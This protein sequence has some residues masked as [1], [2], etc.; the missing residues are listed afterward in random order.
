MVEHR[1]S[2][3]P[4][5]SW[6]VGGPADRLCLA[7]TIEQLSTFLAELA[8]QEPLFWM[9]RGSNLLIRDGG[10]RGTVVM[11]NQ[12]GEGLSQPDEGMIRAEAGVSLSR[13]SRFA[14]S[15]G[16]QALDFVAGIPGSVGGALAM[17]AG[18]FG[19]EIWELVESVEVINRQGKCCVRTPEEYRIDYRNVEL[20]EPHEEWFVAATFSQ[21]CYH[22]QQGCLNVQQQ[23]RQRNQSQPMAEYS[24]GS[25]FRNPPGDHA[26]RLIE[27]AGLK[28]CCI[29]GAC[30]STHH[31]NFIVHRG[32]A[33]AAEIEALMN[34]VQQTVEQQSGVR[35]EP[36]VK[37]AGEY[38][39]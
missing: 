31:A 20:K 15:I 24:C 17:N 23:L 9:G 13:L 10:I 21:R 14:R 19:Q 4:Y 5:T 39:G 22:P 11:L 37:I 34:H 36:E 3:A 2:L 12:G 26:G 18:A 35:L 1:V 33:S 16:W 28:G 32:E 27:S 29:G 7:T 8:D 25:V 38:H 6:Q 30:V